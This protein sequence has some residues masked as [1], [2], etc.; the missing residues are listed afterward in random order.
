MSNRYVTCIVK[1][2][3]HS[4]KHHRIT[5]IGVT[6]FPNGRHRK[7]RTTAA[8]AEAK[9]EA[10][11]RTYY[12]VDHDTGTKAKVIVVRREGKP[13]L[14]TANDDDMADNLLQKPECP[15]PIQSKE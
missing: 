5:A 8:Q 6:D 15:I 4:T 2:P 14:K 13:Y 12:S 1:H 9:I 10:G 11:T 7:W 3:T